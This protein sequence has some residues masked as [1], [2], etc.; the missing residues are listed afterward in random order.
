MKRYSLIPDFLIIGAGKSGTTSI[1]QYLK[2]HPQIFIP[3]VKEPNFFGYENVRVEDLERNNPGEVYQFHK[4]VKQLDDYLKLFEKATPGQ[5]I[6]ETSNLYLKNQQAPERIRYYNPDVKLIAVLRNPAERLF[7]RYL[8]LARENELPK[9]K[10]EDCLNKNSTWWQR[11][12]LI[13]EGFYFQNLARYYDLFPKENLRIFLYDDFKK[14]PQGLL[15][16]IYAF[17]E[18]EVNFQAD[19]SVKYNESGF[20]KDNLSNKIFGR[21]GVVVSA[22]K[23][24]LPEGAVNQLKNSIPIQR[25]LTNVRSRNLIRPSFD[26]SIKSALLTKVYAEDITKLSKLIGRDLSKWLGTSISS[27]S[28]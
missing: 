22:A 9:E 2:Q 23:K 3:S 7:S 6:G 4:A 18:V 10:F 14:D 1:D 25:M 15:R 17:L 16:D 5:M 20:V 27:E 8:H 19:M 12:D 26:P 24:I 28:N 13:P 21:Q 11:N